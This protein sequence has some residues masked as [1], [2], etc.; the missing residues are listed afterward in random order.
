MVGD[1]MEMKAQAEGAIEGEANDYRMPNGPFATSFK[2]S[3]FDAA[4]ATHRAT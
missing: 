1:V 3:R 4:R 2:F